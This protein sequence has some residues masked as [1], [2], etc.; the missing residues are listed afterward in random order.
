MNDCLA[1][2][3]NSKPQNLV[4]VNKKDSVNQSA[5]PPAL[6]FFL[7][8][9]A[10]NVFALL[11]SFGLLDVADAAGRFVLVMGTVP[12]VDVDP[13]AIPETGIGILLG[14]VGPCDIEALVPGL[15]F[16]AMVPDVAGGAPELPGTSTLASLLD[17]LPLAPSAM[18]HLL[19]I[20]GFPFFSAS[21]PSPGRTPGE[22]SECWRVGRSAPF[23]AR[24]GEFGALNGFESGVSLE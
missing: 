24:N 8:P 16:A 13:D 18:D 3:E 10:M 21:S 19:F 20:F 9:N 1:E 23:T 15:S 22:L 12:R 17:D 7:L 4:S 14:E 6:Y 2:K 11:A 5:R